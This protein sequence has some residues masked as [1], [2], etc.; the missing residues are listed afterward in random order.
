MAS[1]VNSWTRLS[2]RMARRMLPKGAYAALKR[3]FG[4][5]ARRRKSM[6]AMPAAG[7]RDDT[8]L[9]RSYYGEVA[10]CNPY[11]IHRAIRR[12]GVDLKILWGVKDM[13]VAVP[14]GGV[15]VVVGSKEWYETL[16]TAKYQVWNVHQPNWYHKNPGQIMVETFHGYPFKL[17]GVPYWPGAGFSPER[18][19]SFLERQAEWDY[20]VS[21]APY[22]TPLLEEC[23]PGAHHMLE[24]GYPR[25]DIFFEPMRDEIRARV[26]A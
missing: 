6:A 22:A 20:L 19:R 9:L 21:P 4:T 10:N 13:S 12:M 5:A 15:P 7:L 1:T 8:I 23:F 26:R 16:A 14:E 3:R 24:I 2:V 25:N 17:A 11:G 18:I